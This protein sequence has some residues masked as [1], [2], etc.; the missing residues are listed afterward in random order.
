M[1][2]DHISTAIAVIPLCRPQ[3][4]ILDFEK[5]QSTYSLPSEKVRKW[6]IYPRSARR[7]EATA[8]ENP[9]AK[10]RERNQACSKIRLISV[11]QRYARVN[12]DITIKP[13]SEVES[14][15][16]ADSCHEG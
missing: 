14:H 4:A 13:G 3:M 9:D 8:T 10:R 2:V 6:F 7:N 16:V 1:F 11:K 5:G 15:Q 12:T